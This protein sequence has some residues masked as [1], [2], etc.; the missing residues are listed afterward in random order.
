MNLMLCSDTLFMRG[1]IFHQCGLM[2][3]AATQSTDLMYSRKLNCLCTLIPICHEHTV[4]SESSPKVELDNGAQLTFSRSFSFS[5]GGM[6]Q[7][8]SFASL[9]VNS[10]ICPISFP[11]APGRYSS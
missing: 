4:E 10:N 1:K 8:A 3:P 6:P 9:L 5:G 11:V 2:I 7:S